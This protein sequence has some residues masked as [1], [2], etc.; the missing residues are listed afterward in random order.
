MAEKVQDK[1]IQKA[2]ATTGKG[3]GGGAKSGADKNARPE[4]AG[5]KGNDSKK[6]W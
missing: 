1:K 3:N 2:P 6:K 5:K 4:A